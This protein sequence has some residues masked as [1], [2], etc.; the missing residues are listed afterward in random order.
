MKKEKLYSYMRFG[1]EYPTYE[2]NKAL[3]EVLSDKN[4]KIIPVFPRK[5]GNTVFI[6]QDNK[7]K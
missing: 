3:A 2:K 1:G 7:E 4:N 6:I 5:N